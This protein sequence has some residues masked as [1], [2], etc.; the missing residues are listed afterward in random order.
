MK[1]MCISNSPTFSDSGAK[2]K[3]MCISEYHYE[4]LYDP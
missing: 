1:T 3:I 4:F 2:L